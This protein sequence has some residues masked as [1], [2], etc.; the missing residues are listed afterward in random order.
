MKKCI[1]LLLA[2]VICIASV[3]FT[4]VFAAEPVTLYS[5]NFDASPVGA[6]AT[7]LRMVE[8]ATKKIFPRIAEEGTNRYLRIYAEPDGATPNL[9]FVADST[10]IGLG[11]VESD[12]WADVRIELDFK[13]KTSVMYVNG[14]VVT[15]KSLNIADNAEKGEIRFCG[16]LEPGQAVCFDDILITTSAVHEVKKEETPAVDATKI[17][18]EPKSVPAKAEIP[19]GAFFSMIM[20]GI[21][22]LNYSR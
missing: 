14:S 22:T 12:K 9:Q 20:I 10:V 5:D 6:K 17:P 4:P 15:E 1:A 18:F 3:A 2:S 7:G 21:L 11:K 8:N 16:T 13:K 19:A